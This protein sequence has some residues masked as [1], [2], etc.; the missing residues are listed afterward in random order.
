MPPKVRGAFAGFEKAFAAGRQ[1]AFVIRK[2]ALTCEKK[3]SYKN[4]YTMYREEAIGHI[5]SFAADDHIVSTT[6]MEH[7]AKD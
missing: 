3:M 5:V 4:G 7:L 1:A 2:G 6:G